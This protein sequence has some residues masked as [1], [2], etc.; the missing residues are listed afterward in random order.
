[1]AMLASTASL[2]SVTVRRRRA[3]NKLRNA[4]ESNEDHG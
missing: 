1:M 3:T 2:M 4:C